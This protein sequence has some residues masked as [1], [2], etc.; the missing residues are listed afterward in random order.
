MNTIK[1]SPFLE[2]INRLTTQEILSILRKA[3]VNYCK[4]SS[5]QIYGV[6]YVIV[7]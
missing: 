3:K 2:M 1:L 7:T 6:I 4:R 5:N